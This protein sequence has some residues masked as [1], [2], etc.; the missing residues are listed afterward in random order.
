M[1]P[2]GQLFNY[3][4]FARGLL[5]CISLNAMLGVYMMRQ[6][7]LPQVAYFGTILT[8]VSAAAFL[9]I[10]V[11]F[12]NP[13]IPTLDSCMTFKSP[14]SGVVT[15]VH[16]GGTWTTITTRLNPD[17]EH[18][19]VS[20]IAGTITKLISNPGEH[21]TERV[22]IQVTTKCGTAIAF[23]VAVGKHGHGG[24]IPGGLF[25]KR[26]VVMQKLGD[27]VLQG[28]RIGMVRFG[29]LSTFYIPPA[30]SVTNIDKGRRLQAGR[31]IIARIS[32]DG[33]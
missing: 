7:R 31:T 29:S 11:F 32:T 6:T 24:W 14:T 9:L 4:R 26:V 23:E 28:T 21:D 17:D 15:G 20:P 5:A 18:V 30:Y 22:H 12:R 16:K 25:G 8:I 19:I 1:D 33:Q 27:Q 13:N 10:L 2:N 3:I